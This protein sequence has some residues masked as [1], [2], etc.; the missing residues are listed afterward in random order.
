MNKQKNAQRNGNGPQ[1]GTSGLQDKLRGGGY[2]VFHEAPS[3]S[4]ATKPFHP[5]QKHAPSFADA[6]PRVVRQEGST[7]DCGV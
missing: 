1:S 2:T 3:G 4:P 5:A 6:E 7:W